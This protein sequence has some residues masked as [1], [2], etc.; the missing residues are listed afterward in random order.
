MLPFILAEGED[1]P[2]GPG[3]YI[4]VPATVVTAQGTSPITLHLPAAT[5]EERE[6][7]LDGCLMNHYAAQKG[8]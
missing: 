6:L 8:R 7:L 4:Y 3:D 5:V 1:F 2:Y